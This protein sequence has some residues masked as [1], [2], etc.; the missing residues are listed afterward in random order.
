MLISR[1]LTFF[2]REPLV[3]VARVTIAIVQGLFAL[4]VFW[5]INGTSYT[6]LDSMVGSLFYLSANVFVGII[7]GTIATF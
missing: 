7:Y 5:K 4:S 6:D 1:N 2:Y 3:L